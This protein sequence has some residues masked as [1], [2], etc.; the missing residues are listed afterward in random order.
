MHLQSHMHNL[1]SSS[2]M[3]MHRTLSTYDPYIAKELSITDGMVILRVCSLLLE[4]TGAGYQDSTHFQFG[5][6]NVPSSSVYTGGK[7]IVTRNL[8]S[9]KCGSPT[10]LV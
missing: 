4:Y 8:I 6:D 5:N 10:V 1:A 7:V 9:S 3:D 2:K